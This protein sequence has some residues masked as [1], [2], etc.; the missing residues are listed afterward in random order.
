M[1]SKHLPSG[2]I[3]EIIEKFFS[4]PSIRV[5]Q[6]NYFSNLYLLRKEANICM[7]VS[8]KT[9]WA[10]AMVV[11]AGID[12]LGK[13]NRG[14][15]ETVTKRFTKFCE[16]F[17]VYDDK[18]LAAPLYKLRCAM[19]HSFS[20]YESDSKKRYLLT[21]GLGKE[22]VV[23][24]NNYIHFDVARIYAR[25]EGCIPKV[26]SWIELNKVTL[27]NDLMERF[28]EYGFTYVADQQIFV[29]VSTAT[30]TVSGGPV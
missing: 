27:K 24:D 6:P 18:G 23:A 22:I 13:L 20:L 14:T 30:F 9:L 1:S 11:F 15:K 29:P 25:F 28:E 7:T 3:D 5:D 19:M 16:E 8:P 17:V 26:K 4:D 10:G 21:E 12:L 2:K